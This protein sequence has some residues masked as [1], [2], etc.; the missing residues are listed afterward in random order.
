MSANALT[1]TQIAARFAAIA[2]QCARGKGKNLL[3]EARALVRQLANMDKY[4][5]KTLAQQ[6]T[7]ARALEHKNLWPVTHHQPTIYPV[8][9]GAG[10]GM[11]ASQPA[12]DR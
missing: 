6:A 8:H 10:R 7:H 2:A 9:A 12:S 5:A 1:H 11:E 4:C 3:P